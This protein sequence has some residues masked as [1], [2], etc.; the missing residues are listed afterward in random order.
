M[1]YG[2]VEDCHKAIKHFGDE[3]HDSFNRKRTVRNRC[4]S[5][6]AH[7]GGPALDCIVFTLKFALLTRSPLGRR[8]KP[9][10]S[11]LRAEFSISTERLV[12]RSPLTV[13][14]PP[15]FPPL[16]VRRCNE[17]SRP[18]ELAKSQLDSL[19]SGGSS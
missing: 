12:D 15:R 11:N 4:L 13:C 7:V 8:G 2:D 19:R 1:N 9:P 18:F 14:V 10:S 16:K 17:L 5:A 6:A 3:G